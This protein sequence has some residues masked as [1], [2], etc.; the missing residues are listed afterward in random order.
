[1][2]LQRRSIGS[3]RTGNC[4]H[5]LRARDVS[6]RSITGRQNPRMENRRTAHVPVFRDFSG[7]LYQLAVSVQADGSSRAKEGK[8]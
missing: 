1:M 3:V 6:Q 5:R 7:R 8:S 4:V 2:S